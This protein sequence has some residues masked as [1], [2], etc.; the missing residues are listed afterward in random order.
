MMPVGF[1]GLLSSIRHRQDW[2]NHA[3]LPLWQEA[4]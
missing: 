1:A 3:M 4:R 2:P